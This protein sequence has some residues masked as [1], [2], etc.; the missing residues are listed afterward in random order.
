MGLQTPDPMV[1]CEPIMLSQALDVPHLKAAQL[2][3]SKAGAQRYQ[4]AVGKHVAISDRTDLLYQ[5]DC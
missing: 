2:C 1:E 5:V 3:R 4:F